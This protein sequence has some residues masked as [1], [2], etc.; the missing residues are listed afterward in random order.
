MKRL[1]TGLLAAALVLTACQ[2]ASETLTEKALEQVEG[3]EG[4]DI[5]TDSGEIKVETDDGDTI[6]IGGGEIP[7]DL[8]VP[9]PDG[10]EVTTVFTS[11]GESA[12]SVIYPSDRFDELSSFYDDWTQGQGGEWS[13]NA[14]TVT[15][16]DGDTLRTETWYSEDATVSIAD[17]QDFTSSSDEL[18]SVCVNVLDG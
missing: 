3:V 12:V 8:S 5:D 4:I 6:S 10:Y 11:D 14:N 17:C 15:T 2:A 13:N 9:L 18:D 7:D 1:A 16:A